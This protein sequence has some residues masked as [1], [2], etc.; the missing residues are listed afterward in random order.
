MLR[1]YSNDK[2]YKNLKIAKILYAISCVLSIMFL[3]FLTTTVKI[4]YPNLEVNYY[5][6]VY[7]IF[8]PLIPISAFIV[9]RRALK[10]PD[11]SSEDS[12]KQSILK[13]FQK[14]SK[15]NN[16][17][18]N[19]LALIIYTFLPYIF[20]IIYNPF[21]IWSYGG[22]VAIYAN[23]IGRMLPSHIFLYI[24]NIF[25][26]INCV[27]IKREWKA[28]P[29]E[30][31]RLKLQKKKKESEEK[32]KLAEEKINSQNLEQS[33]QLIIKC[34][35]KFFIKYYKQISRLPL[36]DVNIEEDY[37]YAEREERITAAKKIIDSNLS[38]LTLNEILKAYGDVLSESEKEQI[39]LL[40]SELKPIE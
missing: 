37:G 11:K 20:L 29:P 6:V 15:L 17:F 12:G 21:A 24:G 33:K 34:G 22:S 5:Q 38:E 28:D 3:L 9:V 8:L 36:R 25:L 4:R 31:Y 7:Y 27:L 23:I 1:E 39:D 16:D 10:D 2:I 35:F 30:F 14:E 32:K 13:E 19:L 18:A 26:I 40:I